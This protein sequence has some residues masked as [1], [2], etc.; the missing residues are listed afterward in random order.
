[1]HLQIAVIFVLCISLYSHPGGVF[2]KLEECHLAHL[3]P[4]LGL[5]FM[6]PRDA[7]SLFCFPMGRRVSGSSFK[8]GLMDME[9]AGSQS[10]RVERGA[11][12]ALSLC[13][14]QLC[15]SSKRMVGLG[16]EA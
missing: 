4:T 9:R 10:R 1:M 7:A 12:W 16:H 5:K 2:L 3:H 15:S 6:L 14:A 13:G 8:M 11:V